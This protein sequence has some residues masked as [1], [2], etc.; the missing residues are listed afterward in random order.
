MTPAF[1]DKVRNAERTIYLENDILNIIDE[2]QPFEGTKMTWNML[3]SADAVIT[4][5]GSIKLSKDGKIMILEVESPVQVELF[6]APAEGGEGESTNE[7]YCRVGFK[8][9]L[10]A[11]SEYKIHTTLRPS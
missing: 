8:A 6:L 10:K 4:E 11:L 9:D 3:T 2:I 1:T 5:D 7:G